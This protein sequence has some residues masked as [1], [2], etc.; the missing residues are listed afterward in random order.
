MKQKAYLAMGCFWGPDEFFSKLPG[1]LNVRVGY[2]GGK[3]ENPTYNNLG[4]N[5]E[6]V[7]IEFNPEKITYGEILDDFFSQHDPSRNEETRYRS[8][9]FYL[10]E[11][12]KKIAE[13]KK[14]EKEKE[15]G[16]IATAIEPFGKFY[17]AEEY[18]QKYLQKLKNYD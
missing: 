16:K 9:I 17:P 6:M 7:E 4:D 12:Q 18:H 1:V 14:K 13:I 3:K 11:D 5:S 8:A 2:G 10:D 15:F